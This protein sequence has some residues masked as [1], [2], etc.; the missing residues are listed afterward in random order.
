[1][2]QWMVSVQL[3]K[4]VLRTQ[5]CWT[6]PVAALL[7]AQSPL[8]ENKNLPLVF[9]NRHE[10][11][12]FGGRLCFL[13]PQLVTKKKRHVRNR[14]CRDGNHYVR[15]D[16]SEHHPHLSGSCDASGRG[17]ELTLSLSLHGA[18]RHLLSFRFCHFGG[19]QS[20]LKWCFCCL[21]SPREAVKYHASQVASS[22]A[23]P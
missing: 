22:Q 6:L 9:V 5:R 7:L 1:M 20:T 4:T 2:R 3:T 8:S 14:R 21:L 15:G 19:M 23:W 11:D 13:S 16:T 12:H 10:W 17:T 18:E